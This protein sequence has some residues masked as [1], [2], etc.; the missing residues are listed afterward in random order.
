MTRSN[1]LI[2]KAGVLIVGLLLGVLTVVLAPSNVVQADKTNIETRDSIFFSKNVPVTL[3]SD[4]ETKQPTGKTLS[5]AVDAWKVFQIAY[6]GEY[7]MSYNLGD[8]QWV[9]AADDRPESLGVMSNDGYFKEFYSNGKAVTVYSD[10]YLTKA[11]GKLDPTISHWAVIRNSV[12]RGYFYSFDLG[13]NQWVGPSENTRIILDSYFFRADTPLYNSEGKR[14]QA[15]NNANYTYK[16]F[17]VKTIQGGIYVK[18]GSDD[19]WALYDA[20]TPN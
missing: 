5:T 1:V 15:I 8:N 20:G 18:L 12:P 7:L 13:D 6:N 10:P 16:I 4:P 3:Y 11:I 19:Q 17:D 9:K 2:Q 14:T